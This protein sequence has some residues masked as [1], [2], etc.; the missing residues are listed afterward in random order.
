MARARTVPGTASRP[1]LGLRERKKIKT[2]QAIRDAAYRLFAEQG[3]DATP[4]EQIAGAAEVSPSTVLRYFPSKEEIVLTEECDAVM[5]Q[6]LRKRPDGEPPLESVR[7]V[8]AGTVRL[9]AAQ[10]QEE[11]LLRARLVRDVP[12]IRTRMAESHVATGRML[13]AVLAERTGRSVDDLELRVFAAVVLAAVE[14]AMLHWIEHDA[15]DDLADL[16]DRT[17]GT[18]G[19]G[20]SL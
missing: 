15:Q 8:M 7:H 5:E 2:R 1:R 12:A 16:L 3:Y 11:M 19:R 9:F 10:G 18:L 17:L 6:E 14:E 20:L 13:C 4:V